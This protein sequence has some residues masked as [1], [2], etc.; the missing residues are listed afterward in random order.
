[1]D[2][3]QIRN[4]TLKIKYSG[5]CFFIDPWFEEQGTGYS[6]KAI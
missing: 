5:V 4:A 3:K 6:A 2:I 1:M